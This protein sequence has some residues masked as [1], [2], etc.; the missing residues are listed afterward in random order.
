MLPFDF[1][2]HDDNYCYFTDPIEIFTMCQLI[3]VIS[4]I[5]Q[6]QNFKVTKL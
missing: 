4:T 1:Y 2:F 6:F 3:G 5:S